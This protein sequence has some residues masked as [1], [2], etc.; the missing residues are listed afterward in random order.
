MIAAASEGSSMNDP[1]NSARKLFA[2]RLFR[3]MTERGWTQAELARR[4]DMN[5]A[6]INKYISGH[7]L[8]SPDS[9]LR[10][11]GALGIRPIDLLPTELANDPAPAPASPQVS[12]SGQADG[13]VVLSVNA[14]LPMPVAMQ[15]L[16]LIHGSLEAAG[17]RDGVGPGPAGRPA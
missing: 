2:R 3:K 4:A 15:V 9:L 12:L 5:R 10:M 8:P 17:V 14:K 16:A 1:H 7:S 11:A 13:S 6:S